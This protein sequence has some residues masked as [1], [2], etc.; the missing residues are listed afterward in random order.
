MQQH[1][2]LPGAMDL[3]VHLEAVYRKVAG[4]NRNLAGSHE[5]S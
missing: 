1:E 4:L 2:R 5:P 3:V